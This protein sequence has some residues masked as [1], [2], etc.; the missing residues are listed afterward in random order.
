M[1]MPMTL[2]PISH[3]YVLLDRSG[4][5]A[6]MAADVV[7]GFNSL[8]ADQQRAGGDARLTLVQFDSIDPQEVL[9]DAKRITRVGPLR[10]GDFQPR[11]GTPLLDATGRLI[12][13]ATE[14]EGRRRRAGK[15]PEAVVVVTITDGEE[16]QSRVHT[17]EG[18]RRL[19]HAKQ[20]EGWTFV[21][22]GAGLDAYAEAGSI[23]IDPRSTQAWAPDG[24]GARAAMAAVSECMVE[25]RAKLRAG[26]PVRP[27]DFF[28]GRK[29]AEAD[30]DARQG[31]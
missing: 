5:M 6:A 13:R 24:V 29:A 20:A 28:E 3:L 27:D 17:R 14:R 22:L 8:L 21:F 15:R 30:R 12:D 31:A 2:S 16:N 25:R 26:A 7:G 10:P 19:V 9:V 4:S 11:G 1:P 18:I 23:G